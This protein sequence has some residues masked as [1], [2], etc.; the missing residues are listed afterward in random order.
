MIF[1]IKKIKNLPTQKDSIWVKNRFLF[2]GISLL[3]FFSCQNTDKRNIKDYYYPLDD[4]TQGVVYEYHP[5][6]ND[7]YPIEFWFFEKIKT[8]TATYLT[9]KYFDNNFVLK[10]YFKAELVRNGVL[11]DD[12]TLVEYDSLGNMSTRPAEILAANSFPF[13]VKDSTGLFLFKLRWKN[14]AAKD[15]YLELVRNRR[16]QGDATYFFKNKS[17]D[18]VTFN[19]KELVDDY[20]EGH[21]EQQYDGKEIYAKHLGLIYYRKEIG[22]NFVLEYELVDT[23]S[24]AVFEE[25]IKNNYWN[26]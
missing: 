1:S 18:A 2:F 3:F 4:W 22:E 26:E 17:Y 23:F 8:D 5:I 21:L 16:F 15:A 14:P 20:N 25:K 9:G 13:E 24:R 12:Y 10:Q 7:A 11:M 6:N 19:V